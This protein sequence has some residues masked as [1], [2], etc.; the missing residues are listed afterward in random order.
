MVDL[1][2]G[3]W[4]AFWTWFHNAFPW[5]YNP[6]WFIAVVGVFVFLFAM[7][8]LRNYKIALLSLGLALYSYGTDLI[9]PPFS[10]CTTAAPGSELAAK[11]LQNI[12]LS[13]DIIS[14]SLARLGLNFNVLNVPLK[15]PFYLKELVFPILFLALVGVAFLAL[16]IRRFEIWSLPIDMLEIFI[17]FIAFVIPVALSVDDIRITAVRL[18]LIG[19][20]MFVLVPL[21]LILVGTQLAVTAGKVQ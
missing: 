13:D 17:G 1:I 5:F 7:F 19:L 11:A 9:F 16:R 18:T 2:S 14:C 21:V 6:L 10:A 15:T 3:L 20:L 4:T 8:A 12:P